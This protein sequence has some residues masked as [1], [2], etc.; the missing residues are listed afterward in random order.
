MSVKK[1][2]QFDKASATSKVR[3]DRIKKIYEDCGWKRSDLSTRERWIVKKIAIKHLG[4]GYA[5]Y[6]K[7]R[8]K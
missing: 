8:V 7:K 6:P 5:N 2:V 1:K 4:Y 3:L